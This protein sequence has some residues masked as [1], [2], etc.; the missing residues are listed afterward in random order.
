MN[1]VSLGR[2]SAQATEKDMDLPRGG[3]GEAWN[4]AGAESDGAGEGPCWLVSRE[5][6]TPQPSKAQV[7]K[8]NRTEK[9]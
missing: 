9:A 4:G 2:A 7:H 8:D 5:A 1:Y 6:K 3:G